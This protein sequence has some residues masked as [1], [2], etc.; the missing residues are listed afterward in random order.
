MSGKQWLFQNSVVP[1]QV[2]YQS[3][4]PIPQLGCRLQSGCSAQPGGTVIG[5]ED[6]D[7]F[8]FQKKLGKEEGIW[9]EPVSAA[10]LTALKNLL[11]QGLLDKDE[12]VVCI[13]SGAGFKDTMLAQEELAVI[14]DQK[15]VDFDVEQIIARI[16]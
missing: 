8:Q 10:S 4:V 16:T 1:E 9:V 5:V 11:A 14:N 2:I 13:M 7:V 12:C 15:P 3:V 6:D